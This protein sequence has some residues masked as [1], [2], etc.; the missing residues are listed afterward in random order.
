MG[1]KPLAILRKGRP[2]AVLSP[3]AG[4][5]LETLSLNFSPTFQDIIEESRRSFYT[6]GGKPLE[7]VMREF[8]AEDS[9]KNGPAKKPAR[10]KRRASPK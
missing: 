6:H 8:A 5:D 10:R 1:D 2:V 4:A 7:E 3:A 9:K